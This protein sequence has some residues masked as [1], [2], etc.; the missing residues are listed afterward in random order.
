VSGSSVFVWQS[1]TAIAANMDF[2]SA[3]LRNLTPNSTYGLTLAPPLLT[4]DITLT[5]PYVPTQT[6]IMSMDVSGQMAANV[7]VDG[8]TLQFS[9]NTL[10]VK[11]GGITT[12]QIASNTI[13]L[14]NLNSSVYPKLKMVQFT[15]SGNWTVPAN[16]TEIMLAGCGGGG[17]GGGGGGNSSSGAPNGSGG[18][19]GG[20]SSRIVVP[21]FTVTPGSTANITIGAGGTAGTGGTNANG[22]AGGNGG[23]TTIVLDGHTINFYGANGGGAGQRNSGSDVTTS[24]LSTLHS[25]GGLGAGGNT[26]HSGG[27]GQYTTFAGGNAGT[28]NNGG[29]GGGG[30]AGFSGR[31]GNGG[32]GAVTGA[33]TAGENASGLGFGSGGGGGGG[34]ANGTGF[35]GGAGGNGGAGV[36]Q[37]YY[38]DWA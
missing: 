17:G 20:G 3:I 22:T 24:A 10:S 13:A 9:S 15:S 36:L 32:A 31:G 30:G 38:I 18:A 7:N 33:G 37:I 4:S 26:T 28:T 1:D 29:G 16:V 5:L 11:A 14:S 8:S 34:S 27:V 6:N 12:T 23:N 35:A 2:G 25:A 19:G 21:Y